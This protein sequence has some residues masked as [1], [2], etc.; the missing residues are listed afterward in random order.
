MTRAEK[1]VKAWAVYQSVKDDIKTQSFLY[2]KIGEKLRQIRDEQLYMYISEGGF[3]TFQD[4]LNNPEIGIRPSTAY[5][6]IG[7]Y[8]EYILRLGMSFEEV[9]EIPQNRLM[10]LRPQLKDKEVEEAREI[11]NDLGS[12][13]NYD[14]DI[15]SEEK[16]FRRLEKPIMYQDKIT[17]KWVIEFDQDTVEKIIETQSKTVIYPATQEEELS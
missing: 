3:D 16:G 6:Y 11:V 2:L 5:N 1:Q 8:E 17:N 10:R 7:I 4:F 14:F 15:V 9:M 12:L 13:T